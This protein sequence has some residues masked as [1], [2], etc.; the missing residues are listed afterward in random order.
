MR[1]IEAII[2]S[3]TLYEAGKQVK[4]ITMSYTLYGDEVEGVYLTDSIRMTE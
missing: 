2:V 1:Q 4:V 3:L